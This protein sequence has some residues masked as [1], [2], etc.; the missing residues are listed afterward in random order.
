MNIKEEGTGTTTGDVA[1]PTDASKLGKP[2]KRKKDKENDMEKVTKEKYEVYQQGDYTVFEIKEQYD[3]DHYMAG[4]KKNNLRY[5]R[6]NETV[7]TMLEYFQQHKHAGFVVKFQDQV[8]AP[9][10]YFREYDSGYSKI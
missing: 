3:F 7:S 8:S 1:I 5:W 10:K 2:K 6:Q 4:L 9:Q